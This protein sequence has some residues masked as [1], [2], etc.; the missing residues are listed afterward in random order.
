QAVDQNL[1]ENNGSW[2]AISIITHVFNTTISSIFA[3]VRGS[4]NIL[5]RLPTDQ[6]DEI[7]DALYQESIEAQDALIA[8]LE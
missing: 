3:Y 1:N 8:S 6:A 7:K 4:N 2:L 5:G